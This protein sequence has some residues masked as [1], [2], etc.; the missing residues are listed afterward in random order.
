MSSGADEQSPVAECRSYGPCG[1]IELDAQ[2]G[3]AAAYLDDTGDRCGGPQG[4]L[5]C[6]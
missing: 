3:T 1:P 6:P 4:G 2:P 5:Q